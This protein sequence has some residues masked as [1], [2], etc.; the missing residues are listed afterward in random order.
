MSSEVGTGPLPVVREPR[1]IRGDLGNVHEEGREH[2]VAP[3]TSW[4]GRYTALVVL[5]DALVVAIGTAVGGW[6]SSTHLG[7][8]AMPNAWGLAGIAGLLTLLS[9]WVWRAWE[10]KSL[11]QGSEE[12]SSVLRGTITSVVLLGLFGLAFEL[13]SVRPWAFAFIPL[14]GL[15][16]AATRYVMRRGLH[17][18]RF[19]GRCMHRVLAVGTPQSIAELVVPPP[20][21]PPIGW[22]LAREGWQVVALDPD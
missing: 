10:P 9:L 8:P 15:A 3:R 16:V 4:E 18:R 19:A 1:R 2:V 20:P 12:F 21:N 17:R 11:G 6:I 22:A 5:A 13:S 14:I 7:V